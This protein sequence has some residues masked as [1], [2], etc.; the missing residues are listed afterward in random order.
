MWHKRKCSR[1]ILKIAVKSCPEALEGKASASEGPT[2]TL[3]VEGLNEEICLRACVSKRASARR[4]EAAFS[5]RN[6]FG[7][8]GPAKTGNDA[9]AFFSILQKWIDESRI[10]LRRG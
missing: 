5:L 4:R 3:Y 7:E 8:G 10:E 1:R 9:G 6:Y 2:Q